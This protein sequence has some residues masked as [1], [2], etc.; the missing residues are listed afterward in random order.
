MLPSLIKFLLLPLS[1]TKPKY[2][3][4]IFKILKL[5][6]P[7]FT[8]KRK[9]L[10]RKVKDNLDQWERRVKIQ[11]Q[12]NLLVRGFQVSFDLKWKFL[13]NKEFKKKEI[14]WP[15][16][17]NILFL[18]KFEIKMLIVKISTE[19][20]L[21]VPHIYT[22]LPLPPIPQ[23]FLKNHKQSS[24]SL[25]CKVAVYLSLSHFLSVVSVHCSFSFSR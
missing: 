25:S 2:S 15:K 11:E 14:F 8:N 24:F 3:I 18:L 9:R 23:G 12:P 17:G 4:L 1:Q 6:L 21:E 22:V 10:F 13:R 7:Y 19:I 20:C 16:K 5:L